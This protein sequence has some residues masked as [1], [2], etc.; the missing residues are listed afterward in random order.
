MPKTNCVRLECDRCG[1]TNFVEKDNEVL[2]RWNIAP[3]WAKIDGLDPRSVMCP[4][5]SA[6]LRKLINK[7]HEHI[8]AWWKECK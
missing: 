6:L 3:G 4:T 2:D 8:R 5:C 1:H 7:H